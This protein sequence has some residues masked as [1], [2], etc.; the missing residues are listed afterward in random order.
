[1]IGFYRRRGARQS[2]RRFEPHLKAISAGRRSLALRNVFRMSQVLLFALTSVQAT[3]LSCDARNVLRR[4]AFRKRVQG[5]QSLKMNNGN[6][7]P[8][9]NASAE[10]VS[11]SSVFH[12]TELPI[13]LTRGR[14]GSRLSE[15]MRGRTCADRP[16]TSINNRVAQT[17]G[18]G[19]GV[20][21]AT[22]CKLAISRVVPR[23]NDAARLKSPDRRFGRGPGNSQA[24]GRIRSLAALISSR[25]FAMPFQTNRGPVY[26]L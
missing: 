17:R 8:A 3:Y 11:Y 15:K 10:R 16:R 9:L 12:S 20:S 1:V 7:S 26:R 13:L 2:R 22:T 21:G 23:S 24:G 6:P 14:S 18:K 4:R 25:L 5:L 19:W